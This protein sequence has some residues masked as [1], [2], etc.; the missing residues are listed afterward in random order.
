VLA[1]YSVDISR[2][3]I[4]LETTFKT[5]DKNHLVYKILSN[6]DVSLKF[7]EIGDKNPLVFKAPLDIMWNK[8]TCFNNNKTYE[9]GFALYLN[10]EQQRIWNEF[11]SEI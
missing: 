8:Y 11:Y 4:R 7:I 6:P 10:Q 2:Y 3:G 1:G 9:I 5:S